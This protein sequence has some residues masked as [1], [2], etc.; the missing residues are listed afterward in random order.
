MRLVLCVAVA[1]APVGT[2]A[3]EDD[4]SIIVTGRG[5][6]DPAGAPAYGRV[7]LERDRLTGDA[8]GRLESLLRDVAGFQ[9]FRR[10]DSRAANPTTQGASLRALGGNA[11]SR[12]L[13]LLDGVPQADPFAGFIPWAALDPNRLA[14]VTVTRGGGGGAFGSGALAGVI[15]LESAGLDTLPR[16]GAGLGG[17]SRTAVRA[18]AQA[19]VPA[20]RGFFSLSGRFDRG[21]GYQLVPERQAGPV[22]VPARY[23]QWSVAGQAVAALTDATS[24][25]ARLLLFGDDR[26]RGLVGAENS[27]DGADASIRLVG[28]GDVPWEAIGYVQSRRFASGF[29]AVNASRTAASPTL[30]QYSTPATGL[31]GKLEL[32]PT[33]GGVALQLGVDARSTSGRTQERFRFQGGRFTRTRE[34][35]GSALTVGAYAE[36]AVSVSDTLLLTG[37][38]RLDHWRIAAGQLIERDVDTGAPTLALPTPARAD[39]QPTGRLGARLTLGPG[40][41]VRAAGYASY[42]LPTLNE[43]YR[44]F[45]VG[46]DATGANAG[47]DPERL[48]G[49]ELGLDGAPLPGLS[50]GLTLFWN[51]VDGAIGNVTR[52]RGPGTF[53]GVGFVAGTYRVRENLDAIRVQGVE[54]SGRWQHGAFSVS[55]SYAFTSAR[56]RAPGREL[57]GNRPAQSPRHQASLTAAY[58]HG[59]WAGSVTGRVAGSSFEDD[60]ESRRLTAAWTLDATLS[61]PLARTLTLELAAENLLDE[62]VQAGVSGDGIL[63]LGTP[64]TLWLSLRFALPGR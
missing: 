24:V 42:R 6:P 60:L 35:G 49:A 58:G 9:Q 37:G 51:Q 56:V 48:L 64:R 17:G 5:L 30:D 28:D 34:A 21:D 19:T 22:D 2:L 46:A 12:A 47:L 53:P 10:T 43:L 61:V 36:A 33:L 18:D 14:R 20:S 63:D 8:S 11:S 41:D 16:L 4:G 54:A 29:L 23:R 44:P 13:V 3:A 1:L 7:T 57:D 38:V 25:Q 31:G 32:R 45:R 59:G 52:G 27:S 40:W 50:I 39:W 55:G 15:A 62:E 26:R